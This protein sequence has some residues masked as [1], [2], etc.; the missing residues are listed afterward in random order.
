MVH[1]VQT[2]CGGHT[3]RP[4]VRTLGSVCRQPG[5]TSGHRALTLLC[6]PSPPCPRTTS[7]PPVPLSHQHTPH[8]ECA[9]LLAVFV[10]STHVGSTAC[11]VP[12]AALP[13]CPCN[14]APMHHTPTPPLH[15]LRHACV[16]TRCARPAAADAD[17][18]A[19]GSGWPG[20]RGGEGG[21]NREGQ[22]AL[23][24]YMGGWGLGVGGVGWTLCEAGAVQS[25]AQL[26]SSPD[27]PH[28]PGWEQWQGE[29]GATPLTPHRSTGCL[30]YLPHPYPIAPHTPWRS[31]PP[32][33]LPSSSLPPSPGTPPPPLAPRGAVT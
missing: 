8:I 30:S 12:P 15:P 28:D 21:S 19:W 5:M 1:V 7:P 26:Q 3:Q 32:L 11:P 13:A 18:P 20:G 29:E 33:P 2:A 9:A 17:A 10:G 24:C 6:L 27:P 14:L 4:C 22:A 23:D 16:N 25:L 31:S